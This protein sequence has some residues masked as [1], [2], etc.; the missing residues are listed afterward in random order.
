MNWAFFSI[1]AAILWGLQYAVLEKTL[2]HISIAPL[3]VVIQ[4]GMLITYLLICVFTNKLE[5]LTLI[6]RNNYLLLLAYIV[7]GS[8]ACFATFNSIKVSGNAVV[9]SLVEMSYP[10]FVVV[11]SWLL[12]SE[13]KFNYLTAIGGILIFIGIFLVIKSY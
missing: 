5:E 4:T 8:L 12:F 1:A 13:I 3:M 10:L 11:F 7:V 6:I 9:A 2:K